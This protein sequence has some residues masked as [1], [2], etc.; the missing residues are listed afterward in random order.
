MTFFKI[1]EDLNREVLS[2]EIDF[3]NLKNSLEAYKNMLL[4]VSDLD[5][6]DERNR[7]DL[8]FGN[9]IAL[10]TSFA[11]MCIDDLVRTRQ[12][13]RG[14]FQAVEVLRTDKD[15]DEPVRILYAGTGPFATLVLP[16]LARYK[17]ESLRL[18]LME[19][20]ETTLQYL[21]VLFKKLG[22]ED[23]VEKYIHTDATVYQ[24]QEEAAADILL[25]ETMQH[26]LVK[27]QQ[28]PLML[29]LSKQMQKN[30]IIIPANIKLNLALMNSSAAPEIQANPDLK[31]KVLADLLEFNQD[32]MRRPEVKDSSGAIELC[33]RVSIQKDTHSNYDTMVVLTEINVFKDTWI[34]TGQSSLTIPKNLFPLDIIGEDQSLI[35]LDYIINKQPY[36]QYELD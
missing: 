16:L 32:F 7:A 24:L 28:V 3:L 26:G 8:Q 20:N 17:P 9:G 6:N 33:R 15:A 5:L 14:L 2:E 10:C 18:Y 36:F 27:E 29:N 22:L 19:V 23:Y 12:F 4:N 31:Y 35:D 25:S 11:A 21:K 13:I 1:V 34:T 30:A